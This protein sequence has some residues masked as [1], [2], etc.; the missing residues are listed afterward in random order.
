VTIRA[1][2]TRAGSLAEAVANVVAGYVLAVLVQRIAYPLFGITTTIATDS[3]IAALFTVT[4]LVRSFVLR[5]IFET[6]EQHRQFGTG[7]ART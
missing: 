2:Q 5:R 7:N 6:I 3:V 4:S 1:I